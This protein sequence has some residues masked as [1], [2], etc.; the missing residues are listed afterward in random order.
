MKSL[1]ILAFAAAVAIS[2]PTAF[3]EDAVPKT[4][5]ALHQ[6]KTALGGKLVRVEGKVVK[7]N[8]GIMGRNF[9]HLQ[10]GSGD[11]NSNRVIATSTMT[12]ALGDRVVITGRAVL[13]RDFGSGYL[14]PLLIEDAAIAPAK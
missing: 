7:V 1:L 13:D 12:A 3:A 4:V 10:D 8:N 2:S 6:D 11:E 9:V 5:A 14:Y